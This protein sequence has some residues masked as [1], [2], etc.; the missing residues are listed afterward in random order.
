MIS[1]IIPVP[2]GCCKKC[3]RSRGAGPNRCDTLLRGV[4][5]GSG[6]GLGSL[7]ATC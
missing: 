2:E 5:P 3:R 7:E 4:I 1:K 6:A